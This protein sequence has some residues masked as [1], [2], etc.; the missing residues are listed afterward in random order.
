M[1]RHCSAVSP[2]AF[3]RHGLQAQLQCKILFH[4]LFS[5]IISG[6]NQSSYLCCGFTCAGTIFKVSKLVARE[7]LP[8]LSTCPNI[9]QHA[10]FQ[11]CFQSTDNSALLDLHGNADLLFLLFLYFLFF[12]YFFFVPYPDVVDKISQDP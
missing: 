4:A 9:T 11:C 5:N 10:C 3:L 6:G 8:L 7:R 2:H 1:G 12:Y